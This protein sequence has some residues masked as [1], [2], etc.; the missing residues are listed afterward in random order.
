MKRYSPRKVAKI[1]AKKRNAAKV[2]NNVQR[3]PLNSQANNNGKPTVNAKSARLNRKIARV[4]R[5]AH[6]GGINKVLII[7]GSAVIFFAIVAV[8]GFYVF[9]ID[10]SKQVFNDEETKEVIVES[11]DD[12]LVSGITTLFSRKQITSNMIINSKGN[13]V[14][15]END[16]DYHFMDIVFRETDMDGVLIS[17]KVILSDYSAY[18]YVARKCNDIIEVEDGYLLVGA[19]QRGDYAYGKSDNDIWIAKI[20]FD[21]NIV[22][23]RTTDDGYLQSEILTIEKMDGGNFNLY[24]KSEA[25]KS[26]F[27]VIDK[28]GEEL[29]RHDLS[30]E[31]VTYSDTSDGGKIFVKERSNEISIIKKISKNAKL[32][33]EE[34][35]IG[36]YEYIFDVDGGYLMFGEKEVDKQMSCVAVMVDDSANFLWEKKLSDF[37]NPKIKDVFYSEGEG[38]I[39]AGYV[40]AS[41]G[42]DGSRIVTNPFDGSDQPI[43][44][45]WVAKMD[46]DLNIAWEKTYAFGDMG[47]YFDEA[48]KAG[49]NEY[50]LLGTAQYQ[51]DDA[52][53]ILEDRVVTKIS[54]FAP[55][56]PETFAGIEEKELLDSPE[57]N[58]VGASTINNKIVNGSME[59]DYA[60]KIFWTAVDGA[61]KYKVDIFKGL[62]EIY[63][64]TTFNKDS[65]V[66]ENIKA[67]LK[68]S[69]QVPYICVVT[70]ID[71]GNSSIKSK[72]FNFSVFN[73]QYDVVR[74]WHPEFDQKNRK[75]NFYY[76]IA[77]GARSVN[78]YR[79]RILDD[80]TI[81]TKLVS[82]RYSDSLD[83]DFTGM[84][85][86]EYFYRLDLE[87]DDG[88]KYI[89]DSPIFEY[90]DPG[91]EDLSYISL[92]E[93]N[94]TEKVGLS[95]NDMEELRMLIHLGQFDDDNRAHVRILQL[96]CNYYLGDLARLG[97]YSPD[98]EPESGFDIPI[99][100]NRYFQ[101]DTRKA[102]VY[103]LAYFGRIG[104]D[105]EHLTRSV[106]GEFFADL[107]KL[108]KLPVSNDII[109]AFRSDGDDAKYN[110]G[111]SF[112][113]KYNFL[114]GI[115]FAVPVDHEPQKAAY[116]GIRYLP[117]LNEE[118]YDTGVRLH[119]GLDYRSEDLIVDDVEYIQEHAGE[120]YIDTED[121]V[122]ETTAEEKTL[123][124][125]RRDRIYS[126]YDG[127]VVKAVES[128][129]GNG[130]HVLIK[131]VSKDAEKTVFYSQHLHLSS[132][133]C[134]V[135]QTLKRGEILGT[136][137]NTGYS[138]GKHL[139]LEI[140]TEEMKVRTFL[141]PLIYD[142]AYPPLKEEAMAMER[143]KGLI[144]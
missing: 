108:N 4:R 41:E 120:T 26:W 122:E 117:I 23:E 59:N 12:V 123:K 53:T 139:H 72:D 29:S 64:I 101:E 135:G 105:G 71:E 127:V 7:T 129:V 94:L 95:E 73:K 136:M 140:Y 75:S 113:T 99:E 62:N 52:S 43:Q 32:E 130:I 42:L 25:L 18:S 110:A 102:M 22:W 40:F 88:T 67:N 89:K 19:T 93:Q 39:V 66:I 98:T 20:D 11:G 119:A 78:L 51:G 13:F 63:T 28:D 61:E 54:G 76:R 34:H 2:K 45:A 126:P 125:I 33:F 104:I 114:E 106:D 6:G 30:E 49:E 107:A 74:T 112:D 121:R 60:L 109:A 10:F 118:E 3:T 100:V 70:A 137:G 103:L 131:H 57:V 31:F 77:D 50:Y 97:I 83:Q 58:Y 138:A 35:I 16:S 79:N 27:M 144:E 37:G 55:E 143:A 1:A 134:E 90:A 21:A 92:D 86:G 87:K 85:Y 46:L 36:A 65:V 132:I 116:F 15:V 8:L 69:E 142:Y 124:E 44:D 81:E 80:G 84:P 82:T 111:Y 17:K 38:Y 133:L 9:K 14:T 141:N 47:S 96:F 128:E 115:K 24:I 68:M 5:R 91:P 48:I 56:V